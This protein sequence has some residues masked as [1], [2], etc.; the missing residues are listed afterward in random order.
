VTESTT[1]D[2]Y[3]VTMIS[4]EYKAKGKALEESFEAQ[5]EYH[6]SK[7]GAALFSRRDEKSATWEYYF[8]PEAM[9]FSLGLIKE[10]AWGQQYAWGQACPAPAATLK[11][12]SFCKGNAGH[13]YAY[14]VQPSS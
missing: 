6:G 11:N 8:T 3:K 9:A 4:G 12:L 7:D 14:L 13:K 5:F 2:W 10:Y 1:A